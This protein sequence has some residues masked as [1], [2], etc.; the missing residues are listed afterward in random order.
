MSYEKAAESDIRMMIATQVAYLD[1]EE[2][3][4]VRDLVERTI[5]NYSGRSNLSEQQKSQLDTAIYIQEKIEES[6]AYDCNRW[7][8]REVDD[9]NT[10]TG[11]YGCLIDTRDGEAILGF[12]GSESYDNTQKINDWVQADFGLLNNPETT[13]QRQAAEFT[14][15]ISKTYGDRYNCYNFTGHSLGGNLAE[16]ATIT[17]PDDMKIGRCVSLDGPGYSLE[18]IAAHKWQIEKNAKY[19][20]HY[21][22]SVVG[23]LLYPLD[24]GHYYTIKA[25]NDEY[26]DFP[27]S[28]FVRH[29]TRNIEFDENGMAQRV[30]HYEQDAVSMVLGPL[31]KDAEDG[32]L[33]ILWSITPQLAM[34]WTLMDKGYERLLEMKSDAQ[35]LVET[36]GNALAT[37]KECVTNWFRSLFGAALT[38]E[39]EMN[40]SGV[41]SLASGF[42]ETSRELDGISAE[43]YNIASGLRYYSVAGSYY[44][45]KLKSISNKV[46]KSGSTAKALGDAAE[47]CASYTTSDDLAAARQLA[48]V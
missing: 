4:T 45:S 33:T 22:Y 16:H 2:G 34:L 36:V 37:I 8:V 5:S 29:H 25:H 9:R 10:E 40:V 39:Y 17:A 38:G 42:R 12:R 20:D 47:S 23:T 48:A 46:G 41:S 31:S 32:A 13:Q 26:T 15:Y 21:Q 27:G 43:I 1:G 44:K 7:I 18:Y 35:H 28:Y 14:E 24:N 30:P 11:F 6:G 3:M 19:V